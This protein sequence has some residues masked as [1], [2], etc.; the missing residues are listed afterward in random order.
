MG[1]GILPGWRQWG[2]VAALFAV[3]G[4]IIFAD[5]MLV[6]TTRVALGENGFICHV[7]QNDP[8]PAAPHHGPDCDACPLCQAFAEATALASPISAPL[9]PSP[10]L[11]WQRH[12]TETPPA[13]A[14][15]RPALASLWPRA[16]PV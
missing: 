14:P 5:I 11:A 3:L 16:P 1:Q 4:Q 10:S 13:R 12:P 7:G 8:G 6:E 15:P 2:L 9:L